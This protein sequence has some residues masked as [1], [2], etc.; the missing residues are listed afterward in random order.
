MRKPR[1]IAA[2]VMPLALAL[3]IAGCAGGGDNS[4]SGTPGGSG[5]AGDPNGKLSAFGTEPENPLIPGNTTEAGGSKVVRAL[6][7]GL[8]E[9]DAVTGESKNA[10]AEKIETKDSKV[11]TVKLKSGWK[12][13][14][15]TDVTAKS[16]V[17]AWN[18][19]AYSPN[20]QQGASFFEQV[21]GYK[22]VHTSDPDG[23]SGPQA[24][25]EPASKTMKGL[26]VIDDSTFEITLAASF[27]VFPL[28]F[29]YNP[30]YPLPNSFFTDQKAFE[31]K[32]IG[33]GPFK[34]VSRT[35]NADITLTRY[36]EFKGEG[37]PKFKDLVFK[38]FETNE[39]AYTATV[40]GELDFLDT[41]PASGIAGGKYK[42]DLKDRNG[43]TPYMGNQVLAFPLYQPQWQNVDL[44]KAVSLAIDRKS[45]TD[46]IFEGTRIPAD[47]WVNPA[48]PGY[49]KGQCG[50]LCTYNPEKAKEH[51][52]K[53]GF[54][55]TIDL[56]TN[57]DG[58]HKEW[59]TATCNSIKN[60]LGLECTY[61]PIATFAETRQKIN[62]KQVSA[63]YRAGW[64]ADYP[65]IENFMNQLYRTGA[66]S[67][68]G[69]YSNKTLDEILVRADAAPTVEE[70][71]K[72]YQE[73][74]RILAEDMPAIPLWNQTAQYGWS[75]RIDNA[76]L[77]SLRELDLTTVTVKK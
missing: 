22:D 70:A 63:I 67:N 16:Y 6:W 23:A 55:G 17:D 35:P 8:T 50:D 4:N 44:R 49:I 69:D 65:S 64:I 37:K 21:D 12:F 74:E 15:G 13:H 59:M 5:D 11:F 31:A 77:S 39:A 9:Y 43:S 28:K 10:H 53:S 61:T 25:P 32:P 72:L 45:I 36:D 14:D 33:N 30:F 26:K 27:S 40:A 24:A 3:T 57:A 42:A 62:G 18:Y 48:V 51:L 75:E 1:W 47:G 60:A 29:G 68:D 76:R 34:F 38:I 71:N 73:G 52:A 58:G 2:S 54:K 41:V 46:K 7:T 20:G 66:S 56:T 19:T